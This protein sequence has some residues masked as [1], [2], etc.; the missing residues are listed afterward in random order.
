MARGA[1]GSAAVCVGLVGALWWTQ[2]PLPHAA[3][4]VPLNQSP[5]PFGHATGSKANGP[6]VSMWPPPHTD[7]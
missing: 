3:A 7:P 5:P 1:W 2:A 6:R 4:G